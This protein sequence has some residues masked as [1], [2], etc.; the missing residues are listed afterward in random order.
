MSRPLRTL[1]LGVVDVGVAA[2][3]AVVFWMNVGVAGQSDTNP[4]TCTTVNGAEISC[5][6]DG[7]IRVA[8]LVLFLLVL[9]VL[10]GFQ[11]ARARRRAREF[12]N[13]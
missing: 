7:P 3:V 1:V 8:Q 2:F 4:P 9:G 6:L 13:Q 10:V 5:S 11:L 12:A